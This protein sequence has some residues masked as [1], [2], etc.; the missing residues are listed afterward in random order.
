MEE[1]DC[2]CKDYSKP[3]RSQSQFISCLYCARSVELGFT[4]LLH[5]EGGLYIV[6]SL[7]MLATAQAAWIAIL[8]LLFFSNSVIKGIAPHSTTF[9]H[10]FAL[11]PAMFAK[12]QA[13]SICNWGY[14]CCLMQLTNSGIMPVSTTYWMYGVVYR[15]IN[16]L[17]PII[18]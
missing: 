9:S 5:Q 3:S 6:L 4:L 10:W 14:S 11:P 7:A 1:E 16:F 12:A 13:A 18:P 8:L 2:F 17:R 15:E